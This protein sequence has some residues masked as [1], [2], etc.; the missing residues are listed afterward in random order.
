MCETVTQCYPAPLATWAY[1][2][3]V[4][5]RKG[6]QIPRIFACGISNRPSARWRHFTTTTKTLVCGIRNTVKGMLNATDDWNPESSVESRIHSVESRLHDCLGFPSNTWGETCSC[7]CIQ[8]CTP[9]VDETI[10]ENEVR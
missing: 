4:A 5:P 3:S 2:C 9:A 10:N 1:N 8:T 6:I 7:N